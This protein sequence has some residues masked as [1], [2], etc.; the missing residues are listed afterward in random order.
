MR[1]DPDL[2]LVDLGVLSGG[3]VAA[4]IA[5]DSRD[6]GARRGSLLLRRFQVHSVLLPSVTAS[7]IELARRAGGLPAGRSSSSVSDSS[8]MPSR[9]SIRRRRSLSIAFELVMPV[10]FTAF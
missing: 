6:D 5:E 9:F 10:A 1:H 7:L 3:P 8:P 2:A 4:V